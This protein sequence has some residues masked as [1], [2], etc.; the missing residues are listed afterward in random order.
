MTSVLAAGDHFV[1]PEVFVDA[2]RRASTREL[3]FD[4]LKLPWPVE[5]FG[6]VGSVQE[7][8]GTEQQLLDAL[9]DHEIVATQ[10]APFTGDVLAAAGNLKFV[11]VCRGG[12]VNVDLQAATD[13]GVIVSY[14]P[15]RNA[16]AAAEFAVGLMLAALRRI[17]GSDAELKDGN[18]R[19]DYYAYDNAGIEL[20][21]STVGLVGYGAIGRI[22]ARVLRAFGSTVLVAD[23]FADPAQVAGEGIE[24]VE[25]EELLRRSSVVSLHARLTPETRNLLNADNLK[26]LPEGA[27]LVNSARGGLLDYAP[28]PDLLRSGRLGALAVDV[29]D[30]EPPPR[31]WPLFDAP[32]VITTPHL[33]GATRQTAH[34]AAEIV[35]GEVGR[36]L[37]G[38]QPRFV[39]NPD[40]LAKFEDLQP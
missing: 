35:A 8:S 4:T 27:V 23:P 28:L 37:E 29:Y 6:P 21:G 13:N 26:L 39:A 20:E 31:D 24:L 1:H 36:F 9:G 10:M 17:P 2:L 3:R 30:I 38:R 12:P 22:V 25:L 11:G 19:G 18:W 16:A 40:V 15:G 33:A 7:A 14:A 32:N 34:R 5:P